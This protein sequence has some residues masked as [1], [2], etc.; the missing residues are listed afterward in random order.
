MYTLLC[1][2]PHACTMGTLNIPL[3]LRIT[4]LSTLY[5]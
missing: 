4:R 2:T 3:D 5:V 1:H